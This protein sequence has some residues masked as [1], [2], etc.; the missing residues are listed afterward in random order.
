MF[1]IAF[2]NCIGVQLSV[3]YCIDSYKDISGE[4]MVTVIIIRNTMSFAMSYGITPWVT[5]MGYQN[6]FITAAFAGM[7]QVLTFLVVVKWGKSWRNA[8]KHRFY[9]Y[10]QESEKLG[11]T[12]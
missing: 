5:N 4:A 3:S 7:A 9:A 12:H 8:S 2:S 1:F 10:V 6:A 11:V